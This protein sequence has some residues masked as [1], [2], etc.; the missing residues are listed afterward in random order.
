MSKALKHIS[1]ILVE[2]VGGLDVSAGLTRISKSRIQQCIS[3]NHVDA[4]LPI[5]V[6]LQLE[7]HAEIRHFSNYIVTQSDATNASKNDSRI[8]LDFVALANR[9]G[10]IMEEYNV[11]LEDDDSVSPQEAKRIM[12]HTIDLQRV[13]ISIERKLM[14]ILTNG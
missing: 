6:V 3:E 12:R 9:F 14:D 11:A 1:R 2:E 7:K 4:Y 10:R 8:V 13:L 5:D